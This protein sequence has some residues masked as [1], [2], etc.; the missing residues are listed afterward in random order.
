MIFTDKI[1]DSLWKSL[2]VDRMNLMAHAIIKVFAHDY[3]AD[4]IIDPFT[5]LL[6]RQLQID[7]NGTN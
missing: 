7:I 1:N 2:S 6:R 4:R 5:T 3:S